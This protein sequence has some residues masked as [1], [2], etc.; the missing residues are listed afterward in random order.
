LANHIHLCKLLF[1]IGQTAFLLT[2]QIWPWLAPVATGEPAEDFS[3]LCQV[4]GSY[5]R[6]GGELEIDGLMLW[7]IIYVEEVRWYE[8]L[9]QTSL[10]YKVICLQ[11]RLVA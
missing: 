9:L 8:G 1:L 3:T 6:S 2:N 7:P 5:L 4:K 10:D 11:Q